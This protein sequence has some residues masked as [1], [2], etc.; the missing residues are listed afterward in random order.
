MSE[1]RWTYEALSSRDRHELGGI[2]A[3]AGVDT[4][5]GYGKEDLIARI[6]D[7]QEATP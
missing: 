5:P 1:R 4:S 3:D 2:A 6:L 7:A